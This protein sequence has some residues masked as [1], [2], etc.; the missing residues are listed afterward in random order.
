VGRLREGNR[1]VLGDLRI[2]GLRKREGAV[3]VH[4]FPNC[5]DNMGWTVR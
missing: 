4:S 1:V 5:D 2:H 3:Y